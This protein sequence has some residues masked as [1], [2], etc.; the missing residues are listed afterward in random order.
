MVAEVW[1]SIPSFPKYEASNTGK[2]RRAAPG[3]STR[4]GREMSQYTLGRGYLGVTLT[5]GSRVTPVTV[6]SLVA[7]AFLGPR[8]EGFHVNHKDL[9]KQN[10]CPE[11][12]EY[13][14]PTENIRHLRRRAGSLG[15]RHGQAKLTWPQVDEIRRRL[16]A[17]AVKR[18]LAREFGINT[19]TLWC[20]EH[21]KSWKQR[22][23]A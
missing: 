10:N 14:T 13:V 20:I 6:H 7:E 11:N 23:G 9:C 22:G 5:I 12:L 19:K 21:G 2:V 17:G 18:A 8:P 4:V 1:R 16:E 15:E 3:P